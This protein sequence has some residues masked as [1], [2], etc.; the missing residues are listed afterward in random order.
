MIPSRLPAGRFVLAELAVWALAAFVAFAA[1]DE[2]P[3][4]AANS[5]R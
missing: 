1:T 2:K 4:L 3:A 5:E